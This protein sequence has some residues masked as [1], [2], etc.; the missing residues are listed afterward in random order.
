MNTTGALET[1]TSV[2]WMTVGSAVCRERHLARDRIE[3]FIEDAHD[4]STLV[5]HNGVLLLVPEH[6]HSV[7]PYSNIILHVSGSQE[8]ACG[9]P[10][11]VVHSS[12]A[13]C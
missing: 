6:R 3:A 13:Q 5:V 2:L 4:V 12:H 8:A 11:T 9:E 10:L 7:L 1:D